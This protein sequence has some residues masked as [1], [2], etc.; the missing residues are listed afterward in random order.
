MTWNLTFTDNQINK[1]VEAEMT[2]MGLKTKQKQRANFLLIFKV[3]VIL[4]LLRADL[5][6]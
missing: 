1:H 4:P 3:V 6:L 5:A 2:E